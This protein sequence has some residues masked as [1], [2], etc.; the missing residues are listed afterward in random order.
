MWGFSTKNSIEFVTIIFFMVPSS[1]FFYF[2]RRNCT[3][4]FFFSTSSLSR[5][6][7][8]RN[9]AS[10]RWFNFN[11]RM[12]SV[13]K[14]FTIE[15]DERVQRVERAAK[16]KNSIFFEHLLNEKL[17]NNCGNQESENECVVDSPWVV[18]VMLVAFVAV[19]DLHLDAAL[20]LS[21]VFVANSFLATATIKFS[22]L[23]VWNEILKNVQLIR[24]TFQNNLKL[25][26]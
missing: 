24:K 25:W 19:Q 16:G 12:C 15:T 26:K 20:V 17:Y 23:S 7:K 5:Y 4:F 2:L 14:G 21:L 13:I 9:V 3:F 11:F 8:R 22:L 6:D 18:A 1:F 10:C